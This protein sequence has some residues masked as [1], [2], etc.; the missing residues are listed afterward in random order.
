MYSGYSK[1]CEKFGRVTSFDTSFDSA[2]PSF[3]MKVILKIIT[4][5]KKCDFSYNLSGEIW[6]DVLSTII[7]YVATATTLYC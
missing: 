6:S 2:P 1:T 3:L 5:A 4:A 7:G